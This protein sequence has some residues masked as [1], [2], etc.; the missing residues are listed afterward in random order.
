MFYGISKKLEERN[1][2]ATWDDEFKIKFYKKYKYMS[3]NWENHLYKLNILNR[4]EISI[5][6]EYEKIYLVG[7]IETKLSFIFVLL[8]ILLTLLLL[9]LRL[10]FNLLLVP[11]LCTLLGWIIHFAY[12]LKIKYFLEMITQ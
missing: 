5:E 12:Y 3:H 8:F 9:A 11:I 2:R 7:N 10:N 6:K 1:Y 4:G